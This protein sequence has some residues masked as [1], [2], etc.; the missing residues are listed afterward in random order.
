MITLK[1]FKNKTKKIFFQIICNQIKLK[2]YFFPIL[3]ILLNEAEHLTYKR[4]H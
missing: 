2:I 3:E 1:D 4:K